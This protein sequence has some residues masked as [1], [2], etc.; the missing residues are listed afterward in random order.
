LTV[1]S[2]PVVSISAPPPIP[3]T[4]ISG[5]NPVDIMTSNL[6][7]TE[8]Q[9]EDVT[10]APRSPSSSPTA[11]PQPASGLD[12]RST[13]SLGTTAAQY[14][15]HDVASSTLLEG[16]HHSHSL[17]IANPDISESTLQPEDYQR[18]SSQS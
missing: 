5:P 12:S 17:A 15:T 14:D 11:H 7:S 16:F 10:R 1:V 9:S 3:S 13:E 6:E 18:D 8:P 4:V 2:S